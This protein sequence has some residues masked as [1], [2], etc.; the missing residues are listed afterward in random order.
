MP[1]KKWWLAFFRVID[2]LDII[3]AC[4]HCY[5]ILVYISFEYDNL[6]GMVTGHLC[7][8]VYHANVGYMHRYYALTC[9]TRRVP[10]RGP[11]TLAVVYIGYPGHALSPDTRSIT[12]PCCLAA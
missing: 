6:Q 3:D 8:H 5:T 7:L 12:I 9:C 10:Y 1:Q 2:S 11:Y 4:D